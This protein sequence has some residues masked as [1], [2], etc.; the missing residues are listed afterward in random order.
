FRFRGVYTAP[1]YS[2]KRPQ[3]VG[4]TGAS[5]DQT[6]RMVEALSQPGVDISLF[7]FMSDPG[8]RTAGQ[9]AI[10]SFQ[11]FDPSRSFVTMDIEWLGT[12]GSDIFSPTE[13]ALAHV[14]G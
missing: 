13:I 10:E 1:A 2:P 7:K 6:A 3:F 12:R 11:S 9:P 5:P 8:F 4:L 14:K